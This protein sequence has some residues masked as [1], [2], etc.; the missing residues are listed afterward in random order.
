MIYH[1]IVFTAVLDGIICFSVR[2][3]DNLLLV[4]KLRFQIFSF[5]S[6]MVQVTE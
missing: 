3:C 6:K 5:I 1:E 2:F 4:L